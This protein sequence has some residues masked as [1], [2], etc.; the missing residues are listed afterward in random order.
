MKTTRLKN[1]GSF[2]GRCGAWVALLLAMA[3]GGTLSAQTP[4]DDPGKSFWPKEVERIVIPS[5]RGHSPQ[6]AMFFQAPGTNPRPLIV[7]LHS[8]SGNFEQFDPLIHEV[9]QKGYHYMHPD[10]RGPNTRPE[11]CGSPMVVEDIEDAIAYA[12]SKGNVD[13]SEIHIIGVSGGGY[14]TL[15]CYTRIQ[16][17]VKSFSAWVPISNVKDWF[18]ETKSRN[19]PYAAHILQVTGPGATLNAAEAERRSPIF[20]PLPQKMPRKG[21]LFLYAGIHDG[22]TGSVPV[23]QSIHMFN[24]LV[25]HWDGRKSKYAVPEEDMVELL[26]K[27]C[28]P[29]ADF[30]FI[31]SRKRH[32]FRQYRNIFLTLF[33][34]GHEQLESVALDLVPIGGPRQ[35]LEGSVLVIGAS[36]E[37][38]ADSWTNILKRRL[39]YGN[40][41]RYAVSGNTIGYDNLDNPKLNTLRNADSLIQF[42]SRQ[43]AEKPFDMILIALGTNDCKAVFRGDT[44]TMERHFLE[45][46]RR[47]RASSLVDPGKTRFLYMSPPPMEEAFAEAKYQG[48]EACVRE[49]KGIL[50]RLAQ[51][52]GCLFFDTHRLLNPS[53]GRITYDGV[54]LTARS[55]TAIADGIEQL[56][57][58][59]GN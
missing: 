55:Q 16:R 4:W 44:Q 48:G 43:N 7:S 45:L 38:A 5:S 50:E 29:S 37:T 59:P 13:T 34:G 10:F 52:Q 58:N 56:L 53:N 18:W 47:L 33:E 35:R 39:T 9:I 11:A 12:V 41:V 1:P 19:L 28:F 23:T 40:L 49:W 32:Y 54:H 22:Y 36:N 8:W 57:R 46:I 27:R 24:R 42:A 30:G 31:G 14:A 20:D 17:P 26:S 3:Q 2:W 21:S 51:Q 15:L 6:N 25:W